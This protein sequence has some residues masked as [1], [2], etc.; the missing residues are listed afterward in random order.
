MQMGFRG[1]DESEATDGDSDVEVRAGGGGEDDEESGMQTP[2]HCFP[3]N[4]RG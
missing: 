3:N 2:L 4:F 1:M